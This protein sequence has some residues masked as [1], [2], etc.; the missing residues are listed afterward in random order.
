MRGMIVWVSE[1]LNRT[2]VDSVLL[3]SALTRTIMLQMLMK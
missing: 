1:V 2:V 3:R